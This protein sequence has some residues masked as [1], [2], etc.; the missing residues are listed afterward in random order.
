MLVLIYPYLFV[1]TVHAMPLLPAEQSR[2]DF[3]NYSY[4][5]IILKNSKQHIKPFRKIIES[6]YLV[7]KLGYA[8][9]LFGN[10]SIFLNYALLHFLHNAHIFLKKPVL[11]FKL[12]SEVRYLP[13]PA[14]GKLLVLPAFKFYDIEGVFQLDIFAYEQS[15]V[16]C[17]LQKIL[18][19]LIKHFSAVYYE[20]VTFKFFRMTFYL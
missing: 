20:N 10:E 4:I 18:C 5:C 16:L 1:N 14:V 3:L 15:I 11:C 17:G 12:V 2:C 13:F 19:K 6:R 9:I 7:C 8:F